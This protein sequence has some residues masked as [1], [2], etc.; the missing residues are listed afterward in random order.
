MGE[1]KA[2]EDLSFM[3]VLQVDNIVKPGM[4]YEIYDSAVNRVGTWGCGGS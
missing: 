3:G 4:F 1:G 2:L